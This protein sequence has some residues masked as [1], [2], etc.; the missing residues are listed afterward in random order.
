MD[1]NQ[2]RQD[3][4]DGTI[5]VDRLVDLVD[6]QRKVIQQ[7]QAQV[8][9]LQAQIDKLNAQVEELKKKNP[10]DRLDE[11][12][13]EKAEEKRQAK[14][15]GKRGKK[16]PPKRRGRLSTSEK[17]ARASRTERVY[18]DDCDPQNCKL[19]HTRVA[20]RLEDG[21]AVLVAYE[22]YR[23]GNR[24]GQPPG[25]PGRGEFGMEILIALAY[26]VYALGL[27]LDKACQV[28][29]FFQNLSLKKSQANA[30]L[31][32][33]AR[34]WED[35]FDT[36]C[37]LLA[38]SAVVYCDETGWSINSVWAF[39]TDTLTVM[40]YGVHKDGKTLAQI[41]DKA[42]FAGVLVSD[43][44]AIYQ[45]F[46]KAQKCWAHLLRK[47]IKL[48]LQA[49][50]DTRYRE[51]TDSLLSIYRT[52]KRVANDNRFTAV[53]RQRRVTELEEELLV[54]CSVHSLEG[55]ET[56]GVED[57]YRRL[58]NEVMRLLLAE[59]LFVFVTSEGVDGDNN[60][61][62]RELRDDAQRR[63]TGR[64]NKKPT[65]AK[66]QSIIASVLRTLGKQLSEFTLDSV[67]A[68]IQRWAE[69]GRS[70]FTDQ[71]KA[72]GLNRP[73]PDAEQRSLLDR[74]ILD[75]DNPELAAA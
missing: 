25:V 50:E 60:V 32:Q 6:S 51:L 56:E 5:D 69:R 17:I 67:L 65:G 29:G 23:Q 58:V 48:T 20:W 38:N 46:S 39:L 2:L 19:S 11:A 22:I 10:T 7:Q 27:S 33:L 28:L 47:A 37:M 30:L 3:V 61:S 66:R 43:D 49:P 31:N 4:A 71:A 42:T 72:A 34:V 54:L 26:Q 63:D 14:A 73:P 75:V 40:F 18:P 21:R 35:E 59:E 9:K 24:Y 1:V 62:E 53:G 41:L 36:L 52:A 57:D 45:G 8:E 68:E 44:A 70:C 12:F 64:T 13:S 55:S 16:K 15:K 74:I